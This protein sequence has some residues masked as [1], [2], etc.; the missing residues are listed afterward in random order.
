MKLSLLL[1]P[2]VFILLPNTVSATTL[3]VPFTPQAPDGRWGQ[4]WQDACEEA[5]ITMV[6][7]FYAGKSLDRAAARTLIS[8]LVRMEE[9]ALGYHRDTGAAD[10]VNIINRYFHW[11]ARVVRSPAIDQI[12]AEID[13]GQP[14]ILPV[15]GRA[16]RNP[17][18]RQGG[19]DYHTVVISGY[20]DDKREFITQEP[21]TR[22]GQN[23]RYS[24]NRLMDAMH[25]FVPNYRTRFGERVAIFTNRA[26]TTS[27][28]SD[29]DNDGL[30]KIEELSYGTILWLADSDGD[31]YSDGTEVRAGYSP[32]RR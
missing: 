12:K 8:R 2:L 22:R 1:F 26:L 7:A 25:D 24:Y 21:G 5:V 16:L 3:S 4:P 17:Y 14:V 15:H 6:D 13:A 11:E 29:G 20:D 28:Q 31:D 23:Y 30:S 9:N 10:I 27:A 19:P 32:T 18:F